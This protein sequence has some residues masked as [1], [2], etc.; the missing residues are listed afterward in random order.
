[1]EEANKI[2]KALDKTR[3]DF[4]KNDCVLHVKLFPKTTPGVLTFP[5]T[6]FPK[7]VFDL[8]KKEFGV[9][10]E[11]F[12]V[13]PQV[14]LKRE[15]KTVFSFKEKRTK[16]EKRNA[17]AFIDA[18]NACIIYDSRP[19]PCKLFP[20]I[21]VAGFREQYPFCELYQ[22]TFKDC[23]IES[24]IYYKKVQAYFKSVDDKTFTKF[25]RTPPT[26]GILY[27]QDKQLGEITLD[28]LEE[29]MPKKD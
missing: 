27:L 4:L 14:V 2:A 28:E 11:S 20:F 19:S 17:C 13:V 18:S 23:S 1:P 25:W 21:A 15:E 5:S 6:F 8:L 16:M 12:F 7:R 26:S 3:M 29:M 22:K 24:R 10:P 9:F